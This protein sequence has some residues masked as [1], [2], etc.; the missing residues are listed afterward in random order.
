MKSLK[1][2]LVLI[3]SVCLLGC[4][5]EENR[6]V[7]GKLTESVNNFHVL[8][9]QEKFNQIYSDADE[10]LK[11]K[12]T[13]RQFVSYLEVVKQNDV[14]EL[15]EVPRVWIEN[16]SSDGIESILFGKKIFF[17]TVTIYTGKNIHI[18]YFEWKLANDKAKLVSYEIRES[19]DKR[20]SVIID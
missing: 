15:K 10:E 2:I 7:E 9:N 19:S 3:L 14:D 17:N 5:F 8:F 20:G 12:F 6:E 18:E 16:E 4:A 13:E 11:N 1:L